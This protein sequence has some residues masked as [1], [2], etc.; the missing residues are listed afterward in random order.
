MHPTPHIRSSH[1]DLGSPDR[2]TARNDESQYTARLF[3]AL[4]DVVLFDV[5][6]VG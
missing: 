4:H 5:A 2:H 1:D 3:A 6:E